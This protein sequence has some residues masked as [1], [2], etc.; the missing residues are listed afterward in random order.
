MVNGI[1]IE[2]DLLNW[3][4]ENLELAVVAI[5]TLAFAEAFI[6]LGLLV[7]SALLV[8]FSSIVYENGFLDVVGISFLAFFGALLGDQAGFYAGKWIGPYFYE[9]EFVRKRQNIVQRANSM[10]A[11][12]GSYVIFLGRFLPAI[13]SII[14][15]ML[16]IAGFNNFKFLILDFLACLLWCSALAVIILGIGTIL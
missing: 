14:P 10:I 2:N 13:R 6:G 12:Y 15:A 8:I 3:L 7:S 16:G 1:P 11:N 9:I 4:S 5:P